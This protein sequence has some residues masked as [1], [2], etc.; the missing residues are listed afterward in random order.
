LVFIVP[1][2]IYFITADIMLQLFVFCANDLQEYLLA[3]GY[4]EKETTW[5]ISNTTLGST[6]S[7]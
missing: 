2:F 1:L 3:L 6:R 4:L 5:A 7:N